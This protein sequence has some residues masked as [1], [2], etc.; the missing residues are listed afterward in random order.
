[1]IDVSE[2]QALLDALNQ[3]KRVIEEEDWSTAE[4]INNNIKMSLQRA[5][6]DARSDNEKESLI[7]LLKKVQSLYQ[8]FITNSEESRS[9]IAVELKKVSTDKKAANFYLK[10]SQYR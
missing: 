6:A 5:V 10:S 1:M 8:L 9:K 7:E 4:S 3:L 2:N